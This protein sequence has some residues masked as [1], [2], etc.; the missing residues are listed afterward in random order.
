MTATRRTLLELC[1]RDISLID[2]KNEPDR[3]FWYIDITAVDN[4]T[5]RITAPQQIKGK[6]ASVRARQ[7]VRKNDILVSTTRP[8]LNA[9]ALVPQKYDG[10]VCSTGFCVLRPNTE[11]DP[12]YLFTYT[13]SAAFIQP[14]TDLVQGALYPAVTDKQVF[15]QSI[16]WVSIAE[17]RHIAYHLKA[18]LAAVE[19]AQS[20][21]AAQMKDVQKLFSA[22]LQEA[23]KEVVESK[24]VKLNNVAHIQ[25]GKM[26]S[27]KSKTGVSSFPYLR[28]QNVQWGRID[29]TNIAQM[30]FSEAEK[31]KFS[32]R[33]GDLLVCEGGEPGRCAIWRGERQNYFYQKA[34]HRIRPQSDDLV[35]EYLMYWL[36]Y[37]A[38]TGAFEDQ[39]AKTTI[40]HLPVVRLEQL[41]LPL[42]DRDTQRRI[43]KSLSDRLA[44]VCAVQATISEQLKNIEIL[45]SRLLA[46]TFGDS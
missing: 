35:P 45:P 9:V 38:Q 44:E 23:F 2:P 18:Q 36:W 41:S 14:L 39:N 6:F 26:L 33:D 31:L 4:K 29:L 40:A 12:E 17:Q 15:T 43:A 5:K 37:Q 13:Q 22:I 10:Q 25:L 7:I 21:A 28:N 30:D 32:L 42:P 1:D 24:A 27:P 3:E 16:P 20:A 19:E 11:I 34:L 8:N 46:Q